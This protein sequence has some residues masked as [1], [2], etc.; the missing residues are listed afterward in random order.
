MAQLNVKLVRGEQL[1]LVA[2]LLSVTIGTASGQSIVISEY[3]IPTQNSAPEVIVAGS[4]G[5]LWFTEGASRIG[6]ITTAGVVTEYSLPTNNPG[7]YEITAGPD[8]A[9]WFTEQTANKIGKITTTGQITEYP[10]PTLNSRPSHIAAGPDGALWFNEPFSRKIARITTAGTITEYNVPDIPDAIVAGTDGALWFTEPE[11]A[12]P[13]LKK[14]GRI[15]TSGVV[16]EYPLPIPYRGSLVAITSGPDGALWFTEQHLDNSISKIGRITTAGTI[17]EYPLPLNSLP[18]DRSAEYITRGPDGALWFTESSGSI[19]CSASQ[20]GAQIG[21]I[22]TAGAITEYPAPLTLA[23]IVTGPDGALWFADFGGNKIGR[24]ILS[25]ATPVTITTAAALPSGATYIFYSQTLSATGG[26]PPYNWSVSSG[27]P[28]GLSLNSSTGVLSGSPSVAGT[29]NF[30]VQVLDSAPSPPGQTTKNFSITINPTGA[31]TLTSISPSSGIQGAS[32]AVTLTGTNFIVPA[33]GFFGTGVSTGNS[34]ITVSNVNVVS[35]TT[36]TATLTIPASTAAG[37]TSVRVNTLVNTTN[38]LTF[39]VTGAATPVSIT[40]PAALP[41][42]ASWVFYSQTL[43]ATGGTPPYDWSVVSGETI[44]CGLGLNSSTGVFS[45]IPVAGT[46]NFTVQVLDS[47]HS[48]VGQ[49]TK[50]FSLTI[51]AT[52]APTLTSISPSSGVQG[53][54]VAMTLTGTNFIVPVGGFYGSSVLSSNP[55]IT[56]SNVNVVSSTTITATLTIAA[57]AALGPA[58]VKVNTS[59]NTSNPATFTVTGAAT[60]VAITTAAA[61]PSGATYVYY[62]QTLSA[63]GGTPPYNW[64]VTSGSPCGLSLKSSTGVLSGSPSVAGTCNFTVQVLDSLTSLPGQATKSFSITINSTPAPTL[65]SISPSSGMPGASM[66]VTLTGTNFIVPAANFFGTGVSTGNSGITVSNVNVTSA[67]TLTAA[68]TI[69]AGTATGPIN[70]TVNTLVNTSNPVTFNIGTVA[71]LSIASLSPNSATAGGPTFTLTL[72]GSGFLAGSTVRWNGSALSTS[73]V[74]GTQLNASVPAGQITS[75][76]TASVTVVNP[77]GTTS[78]AVT[79]TINAPT[80][81]ISN[82]SP[83]SATAGGPAFTLTVNGSGFLVGSTVQWSGSALPTNYVSGT[84]LNASVPA[85]QITSQGTASVTVVNPGGT[86][87]PAATFTINASTGGSLSIITASPLL[88]GAVGVP[89]SQALAATGGVTP[90]KGW[91]ISAGSQLPP[92]ISLS[93]IG[94]FL[95][96]LLNGVPTTPGTFSFT[97]QVTDGANTVA[98][99]QFSLTVTGGGGSVSISANGVVNAASYAGGSVSPGEIITIFGSGLGTST[100]VGLQLDSRGY[101]STSLAGT[102]VLFDGVAAPLIY[103]LAGQVSAVVPYAVSG[104]TSTQLQVTYQGQNSNLVA[105]PVTS[106]APG[107]FTIDASGKGAG[108]IVNQDG[109]VNSSVNPAA[110]GSYVFVYATGEGQTTPGG[111]DGKPGDAPAPTPIAQPVTG[112]LGG[113]NAQVQYAGGV[114]GLVAGVLQVNVLV[115]QGVASGNSVPLVLNIGGQSTQANVTLSVR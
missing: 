44:P 32:V 18:V 66:P 25:A 91:A 2:F 4:D 102:Q 36:L 34:G 38:P 111:I 72:N 74:S 90:Y 76:G 43:N 104:K 69:P 20:C 67:T 77:G 82:L 39:T 27:W 56:V 12:P 54:S 59:V 89:Y 70:V 51:S 87:S 31:P 94:S 3:P 92:G 22:T 45:G 52:G 41:S 15:T 8:G 58:S 98:T 99:K 93:N 106:V 73:Y 21:R 37:P 78:N 17:T 86:T 14:I 1:W 95:A 65:S 75:Q 62:S 23:G 33:G 40:T 85:G 10:L 68:L 24:A 42:G 19:A 101:V 48:P 49:T 112:T 53:A 46:C 63:T 5:A 103:T 16:T 64:T 113:V 110:V 109:T 88:G 80:P 97:A 35:S 79:F 105:I 83:N 107:I 6:R 11:A 61:L 47:A 9:L 57:N 96:G 7:I 28:C 29:C 26:T 30:T 100:L 71:T 55:G 60:P 115:P 84:Q 81:S 50:N 108:A 114:P 13:M